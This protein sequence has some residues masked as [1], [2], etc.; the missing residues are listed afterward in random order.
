MA[1]ERILPEKGAVRNS[2]HRH[3]HHELFVFA[4]GKADHMI[5][6]HHHT[7]RKP[8]VHAV[9]SGQVHHL[10][11]SGDMSGFV[12][13][14]TDIALRDPVRQNEARAVFEGMERMAGLPLDA[15]RL[16][17]LNEI[18]NLLEQEQ[19][20]KDGGQNHVLENYLGVAL[21][22]CARWWREALPDENATDALQTDL[23]TRFRALVD[24]HFLTHRKVQDYARELRVSPGHLSD[25][26]RMR[27]GTTATNIIGERL[28]LEAKRLL[29]HSELSVKEVGYAIGMKDPAYFARWFRKVEGVPPLEYRTAGRERYR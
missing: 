10:V 26:V 8:S 22:K 29:I 2:L 17:V 23:I 12:I 20:E 15:K 24:K 25:V 11:R 18:A 5:D 7:S 16:A 9:R 13:M 1:S 14:F 28:Q 4:S 21:A 19:G 6:L 3:D 27:L